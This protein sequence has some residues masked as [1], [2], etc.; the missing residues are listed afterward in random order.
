MIWG[1]CGKEAKMEN[2]AEVTSSSSAVCGL[3][4]HKPVKFRFVWKT[5][6]GVLLRSKPVRA[7]ISRWLVIS[8]WECYKQQ[9]SCGR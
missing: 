1:I 9:Q 5:I 6:I 3:S 4:L 2:N 7:C 8:R